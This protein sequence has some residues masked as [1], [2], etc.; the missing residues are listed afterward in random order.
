MAN[1]EAVGAA[2]GSVGGAILISWSNTSKYEGIGC[3]LT[4]V[5]VSWAC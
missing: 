5:A 3:H 4:M 2:S 1:F